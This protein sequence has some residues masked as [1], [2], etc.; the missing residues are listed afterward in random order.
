MKQRGKNTSVNTWLSF[1]CFVILMITVI[2]SACWNYFSTKLAIIDREEAS[3]KNCA[4]IVSNTL[5]RYG[6]DTLTNHSHS[7][8]SDDLRNAIRGYCQGFNQKVLVIYSVD[9][10]T[11]ELETVLDVAANESFDHI[12]KEERTLLNIRDHLEKPL[13]EELISGEEDSARQ[14]FD[15]SVTWYVPYK[16]LKSSEPAI[17]CMQGS[18]VM[19]DKL[20][21]RDFLMDTL[22]PVGIMILGFGVLLILVRYRITRPIK[23]VSDSMQH[24]T[25]QSYQKPEPLNIKYRDEIGGIADSFEKM[26]EDISDYIHNI[27]DLT[28][29]QTQVTV[30]LEVARRIQNGVVPEKFNLDGS[31]FRVSAM[32]QPAKEVGGDFYDCFCRNDKSV[33]IVMGDVSG[34]GISAA[35]IMAMMKTMLR[36]KLMMGLT[37]AQVL[38]QA[39]D[40]ICG[41]NPEGLFATVFIAVLHPDTGKLDYA[42]AGHTYPVLLGRKPSLLKPDPGIVL[43]LFEDAGLK[44]YSLQLAPSEGIMLYT[45]G[46]TEAAN[47]QNHF[48]GD[49]RLLD[50]LSE[51]SGKTDPSETIICISR[52]V[53][54][55][56]NG[57]EPFDD[58]AVLIMY[59]TGSE[60]VRQ[61]LPLSLS[62]FDEIRKTVFEVA[63]NTAKTR[64]ALL[65]CDELLANIV[66]Y[67]DANILHFSCQKKDEEL[68]ILF[69]D[70]GIPFDSTS[71]R[72]DSREFEEMDQGGMGLNII[73]QSV[74]SMHYERIANRNEL[75]LV[76]LL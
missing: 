33:C 40:T 29:K 64:Q 56:C 2:V 19:E 72:E 62:S 23:E 55:F 35:I 17:I 71:V 10:E 57:R 43:G 76:F 31:R 52:A 34:K 49:R 38:N 36:E 44:D 8:L 14:I 61:E 73:R 9:S 60:S 68:W 13:I 70:D 12:F 46:V 5:N 37:P 24:F 16:D 51:I 15:N 4:N 66:N 21:K 41:Q 6:L 69:S 28:R 48:F 67:S 32:T 1:C 50:S 65:A 27:K 47:R 59:Y 22:L 63:G 53:Y 74:S 25:A 20:I 11:Y 42:N 18:I 26:T 39:N 45:D 30:Q 7:K 54:D 75:T 58:M 3:A